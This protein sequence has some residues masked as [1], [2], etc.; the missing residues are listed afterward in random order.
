MSNQEFK[1]HRV[2]FG[3]TPPLLAMTE[4]QE[5]DQI[6]AFSLDSTP[7]LMP[8]KNENLSRSH[9]L[10]L[11][12]ISTWGNDP[13]DWQDDFV[14]PFLDESEVVNMDTSTIETISHPAADC[15]KKMVRNV[16]S[17]EDREEYRQLGEMYGL[18]PNHN[19]YNYNDDSYNLNHNDDNN[20]SMNSSS[21][22][23]NNNFY[24]HDCTFRDFNEELRSI[25]D[26]VQP[27]DD[28][29]IPSSKEVRNGSDNNFPTLLLP[30]RGGALQRRYGTN[31]T[32][33]KKSGSNSN[34]S[35]L[36]SL[37]I[38]ELLNERQ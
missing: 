27:E 11:S 31:G 38:G 13:I 26:A 14:N 37:N 22:S 30:W 23:N 33:V 6:P 18:S 25:M 12:D 35:S 24:R 17:D 16:S 7:P 20:N 1:R 8:P 9:S 29:T 19:H 4:R 5:I 36:R 10:A 34:H 28:L 21:S 32:T 15:Q 2:D 3:E